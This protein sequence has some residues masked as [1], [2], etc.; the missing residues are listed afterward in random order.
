LNVKVQ[1]LDAAGQSAG[2]FRTERNVLMEELSTKIDFN[3]F[4]DDGG[5][6][7]ITVAGGLPLVEQSTVSQLEV[8]SNSANNGYYD[9]LFVSKNGVQSNITSKITGGEIYGN[10]E[11]RDTYTADMLDRFDELAYNLIAE[12]NNVHQTG[13]GLNGASGNDFFTQL[14][15]ADGASRLISL[16]ATIDADATAIA[17]SLSGASGDNQIANQLSAMRDTKVLDGGQ[18]SFQDFYG[19]MVADIGVEAQNA[20]REFNHADNAKTQM[21]NFLESQSGVV[22]EEEMSNL[23]RYQQAYQAASK[24]INAVQQMINVLSDLV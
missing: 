23:I 10:L 11:I 8:Q 22:I 16:D 9:V 18:S 6:V 1:Q 21:K 2:D 24:M 14:A 3:Y 20:Q 7:T 17:A 4:E 19:A 5:M 13:T 12:V 15:S